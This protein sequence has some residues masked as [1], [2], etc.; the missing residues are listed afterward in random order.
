MMGYLFYYYYYPEKKKNPKI[1]LFLKET[2]EEIEICGI[3]LFFFLDR[4]KIFTPFDYKKKGG[5][6]F[7]LFFCLSLFFSFP[8]FLVEKRKVF[9]ESFA[10]VLS[11]AA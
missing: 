10:F 11:V 6:S 9:W 3:L 1:F 7:F 5:L 2:R 4:R 8:S